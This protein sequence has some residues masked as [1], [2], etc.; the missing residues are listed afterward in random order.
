MILA[1]MFKTGE[2][3][4][5]TMPI[6]FIEEVRSQIHLVL[7]EISTLLILLIQYYLYNTILF[8]LRTTL[9]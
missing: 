5:T 1:T 4:L 2:Q 9:N 3:T 7:G 8:L 6:L